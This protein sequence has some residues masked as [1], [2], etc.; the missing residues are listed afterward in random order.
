MNTAKKA[1]QF[2]VVTDIGDDQAP[3]CDQTPYP[4]L[5]P[6]RYQAQ[7]T[8]ARI[9]FDPQF[10]SWKAI[11]RLRILLTRDEIC[12]FFHLGR[13]EKPKAGTRS[14]YWRAWIIANDA[15]PMKRQVLS[16]RVFVGKIFEIEVETVE[17]AFDQTMHPVPMRYSTVRRILSR[18]W[19]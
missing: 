1:I 5:P 8:Y 12:G 19:P 10:K 13:C 9:Y 14:R 16:P 3:V 18:K 6:G 2:P 4:L 7:C 15:Q 11:L 17:R